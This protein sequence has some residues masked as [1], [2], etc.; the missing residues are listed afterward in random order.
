MISSL[1]DSY[2]VCILFNTFRDVIYETQTSY[3][4]PYDTKK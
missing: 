1:D 4:H 2:D 3:V